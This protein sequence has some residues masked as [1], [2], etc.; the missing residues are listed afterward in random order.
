MTSLSRSASLV[1]LAVYT[2]AKVCGIGL[3]RTTTL[4]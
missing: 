3:Y 1:E 2:A 4:G